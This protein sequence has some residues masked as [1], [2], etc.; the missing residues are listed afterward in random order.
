MPLV[1][2]KTMAGQSPA[3][4]RKTLDDI[5]RVVAENLGYDRSHVWVFFDE[6][7]HD[8]FMT[9]GRTWAELKSDLA[10]GPG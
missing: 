10:T 7:A 5:N 1:T 4:I 6:V 2:V 9:A 8:R 3:A